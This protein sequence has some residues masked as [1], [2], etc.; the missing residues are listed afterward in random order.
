NIGWQITV[1][2]NLC[3]DNR[4][5]MLESAFTYD[6]Q[7]STSKWGLTLA[8]LKNWKCVVFITA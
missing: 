3:H 4:H 1:F 2:K 5:P 7:L 6:K 8:D